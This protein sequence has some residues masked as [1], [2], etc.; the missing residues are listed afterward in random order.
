M[1]LVDQN[2]WNLGVSVWSS[3]LLQVRL[4]WVLISRTCWA[5]PNWT[6]KFDVSQSG[7]SADV[8]EN[9]VMVR[10]FKFCFLELF[11]WRSGQGCWGESSW[12]LKMRRGQKRLAA[13]STFAFYLRTRL[14]TNFCVFFNFRGKMS[15][16]NSKICT[17]YL[18]RMKFAEERLHQ[19]RKNCQNYFF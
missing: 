13:V 3:A 10:S 6:L 12:V 16:K 9:L 2:S 4:I 19:S 8:Q 17:R 1:V 18:V 11:F 7:S 5:F 15:P 14:F